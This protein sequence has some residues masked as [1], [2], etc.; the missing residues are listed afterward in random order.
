MIRVWDPAVR[1]LHWALAVCVALGWASTVWLGGW[2]QRVGWAAL[3]FFACIGALALTGRLYTTDRFRG[4]EAVE[5]VHL[6][7]ASTLVAMVVF[8]VAGAV[9]TGRRQ[10]ENLIASMVH[11]MKREDSFDD[12]D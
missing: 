4:D 2:H 5:R 1:V 6:V 3:A 9:L 10:H 11:G 12:R 7:L 8:R